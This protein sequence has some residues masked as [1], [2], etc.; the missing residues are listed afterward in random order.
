MVGKPKNTEGKYVEGTTEVIYEYEKVEELNVPMDPKGS[1]N[2]KESLFWAILCIM[3]GLL[4][5]SNRTKKNF[6]HLQ[7]GNGT[8]ELF[9]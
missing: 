6:S 4:L 5:I 9:L 8:L 3:S 7:V 2:P 1:N